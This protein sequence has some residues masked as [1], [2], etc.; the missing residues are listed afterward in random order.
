MATVDYLQGLGQ[1]GRRDWDE[2]LIKAFQLVGTDITVVEQDLATLDQSVDEK[3]AALYVRIGQIV[4]GAFSA[5]TAEPSAIT[6][7]DLGSFTVVGIDKTAD[8]IPTRALLFNGV[9]VGSV[10]MSEFVG[11]NTVVTLRDARTILEITDVK[12][13]ILPAA[14][15]D[16]RVTAPVI[17]GSETVAMN[18]PANFTI[19]DFAEYVDNPTTLYELDVEGFGTVSRTGDSIQWVVDSVTEDTI[20]TLKVTRSI[21]GAIQ[22]TTRVNVL[23]QYVPVVQDEIVFTNTSETW[24]GAS[25]VGGAVQGP[26]YSISVDNPTNVLSASPV[27]DQVFLELLAGTTESVLKLAMLV[28]AGDIII[29][30][31]GVGSVVSVTETLT[32]CEGAATSQ[33]SSVTTLVYVDNNFTIPNSVFV[34]SLGTLIPDGVA[35]SGVLYL[36]RKNADS[37]LTRVASVNYSATGTASKQYFALSAPYQVPNDGLEYY[38]GI[39]LISGTYSWETG[40]GLTIP[41][42][43]VEGTD[44]VAGANTGFVSVAAQSAVYAATLESPLTGVP[45]KA[46]KQT[47]VVLNVG[48]GITGEYIGPETALALSTGT[49]SSTLEVNVE[50]S[51][52]VKDKIFITGGFNNTVLFDGVEKEVSA[53]SEVVSQGGPEIIADVYT[54]TIIPVIE[55]PQ[56]P[57]SVA[58]PNR[59][60]HVPAAYT[61]EIVGDVLQVTGESVSLPAGASRVGMSVKSDIAFQDAKLKITESVS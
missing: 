14:V 5:W 17:T 49:P 44:Y 38:V 58:I 54:T 11:G 16:F 1:R 26:A 31:Q 39:Q 34:Q 35:A 10:L 23:V 3:E 7:S 47:D 45:T 51:E 27:L 52:S 61:Q 37:T 19:V 59:Y 20:K 41:A 25:V 57:S 53:V 46:I 33:T 50:S 56:I 2:M 36:L 60:T 42:D 55:L 29:T 18:S 32:N 28:A 43:P 6:T 24:R 40:N 30:D 12:L 4:S 15:P 21:Q 13:G 9:E 22:S 48:A 8:Y